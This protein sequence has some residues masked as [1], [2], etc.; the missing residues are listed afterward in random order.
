VLDDSTDR[1]LLALILRT[2]GI[3]AMALMGALIKI[4]GDHEVSLVEIIFWRQFASVVLILG[5]VLMTGALSSLASARPKAHAVRSVYGMAGMTLNFGALLLLPLAEAVTLSFSA[6][7][8]AVV[9][10]VILLRER[11][12]AWRWGAV[13]AGFVGVL[14]IAQ[15]GGGQVPLFG[16]GVGLA[17]ALMIALISIQ[18]RDLTRTEQSLT[19]VFWFAAI[20]VLC[21]LP[22]LLIFGRAQDPIDWLLLAGIGMAGTVGQVLTTMALRYGNVSSVIVMDYSGLVW[23]TLLGFLLFS[24]LPSLTTWIGAPLVVGA[25][26][27]IAWREQVR[28][29]R[30]PIDSRHITG[31]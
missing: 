13:A 27:I 6:P 1:P 14:I 25:G 22:L 2:A 17:G 21:T 18:V 26:L 15:P 29:R 4:A 9:L 24:T 20:T 12:H 3:G 23:A 30:K 8:F 16:A 11:V 28:S 10:S 19:I 5:W 7:I 31:T